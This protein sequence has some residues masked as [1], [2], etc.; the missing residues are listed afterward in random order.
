MLV[1]LLA[2]GGLV[3]VLLV[4]IGAGLYWVIKKR[5]NLSVLAPYVL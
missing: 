5:P 4:S 2:D 1:T 3:F